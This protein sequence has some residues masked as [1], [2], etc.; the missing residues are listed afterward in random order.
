[1]V[2]GGQEEEVAKFE[3]RDREGGRETEGSF[4]VR[5]AT[6]TPTSSRADFAL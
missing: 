1:M 2:V 6:S 3:T 4:G 5:E